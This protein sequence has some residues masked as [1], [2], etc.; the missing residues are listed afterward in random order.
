MTESKLSEEH[1]ELGCG[2]QTSKYR[3]LERQTGSGDALWDHNKMFEPSFRATSEVQSL[4]CSYTLARRKTN[5]E[6]CPTTT[7]V[8]D[9]YS[10][11]LIEPWV[12]LVISN[13]FSFCS[14]RLPF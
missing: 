7:D 14:S 6:S 2:K 1:C 9:P 5:F 3:P 12:W 11:L 13:K 8:S 10:S 4:N